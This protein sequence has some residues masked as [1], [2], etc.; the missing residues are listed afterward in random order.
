MP[1]M[2]LPTL[3]GRSLLQS[4]SEYPGTLPTI[5]SPGPALNPSAAIYPASDATVLAVQPNNGQAPFPATESLALHPFS[6]PCVRQT[7]VLDSW[8]ESDHQKT[9]GDNHNVACHSCWQH[10][11]DCFAYVHPGQEDFRQGAALAL[12]ICLSLPIHGRRPGCEL[13]FACSS[14]NYLITKTIDQ[15]PAQ[16]GL[17][18]ITVEQVKAQSSGSA[19]KESIAAPAPGPD[20]GLNTSEAAAANAASLLTTGLL[21]IATH[22]KAAL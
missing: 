5:S 9:F 1:A 4:I 12:Q 3:K 13:Y 18:P 16:L 10:V 17:L 2:T 8:S 22:P 11:V 15:T 19:S 7:S 14:E 21:L 20:P 6:E